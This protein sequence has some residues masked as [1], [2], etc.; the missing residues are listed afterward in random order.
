MR[1][2]WIWACLLLGGG[3]AP[4]SLWAQQVPAG[5][6]PFV[7]VVEQR[8]SRWAELFRMEDTARLTPLDLRH[9]FPEE[10]VQ[11]VSRVWDGTQFFEVADFIAT[12]RP[13]EGMPHPLQSVRSNR[14]ID[15][16]YAEPQQNHSLVWTAADALEWH[17]TTS[18]LVPRNGGLLLPHAPWPS[19]DQIRDWGRAVHSNSPNLTS[20]QW[21][22]LTVEYDRRTGVRTERWGQKDS[23]RRTRYAALPTGAYFRAELEEHGRETGANGVC[24]TGYRR[25]EWTAPR[26]D[27]GAAA[28]RDWLADRGWS[29]G[30][31][32]P[33]F[34]AKTLWD[35]N[36][37]SAGAGN[38]PAPQQIWVAVDE[39]G[40]NRLYARGLQTGIDAEIG[41]TD[42]VGR[43]VWTHRGPWNGS[44]ELADVPDNQIY[45]VW[46]QHGEQRLTTRWMRAQ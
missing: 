29:N 14:G 40:S 25:V 16:Y 21:D 6:R 7:A 12:N 36:G 31:N 28:V 9:F 4:P 8:T 1:K 35:G 5:T 27:T 45:T 24:W 26:V 46:I 34:Q 17:E 44:L 13:E 11:T 30:I 38:S 41:V 39:S 32:G 42:A 23:V 3:G 33:Y 19:S 37:A 2:Q 15:F 22:D 20:V 18:I 10:G 43:L